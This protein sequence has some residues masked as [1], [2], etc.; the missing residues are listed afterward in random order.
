MQNEI[1]VNKIKEQLK[2]F[3]KEAGK[4][5]F[6]EFLEKRAKTN[7]HYKII[8][9]MIRRGTLKPNGNILKS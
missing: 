6:N 9:A 2:K 3:K 1:V 8:K 7:S 4:K 5:M